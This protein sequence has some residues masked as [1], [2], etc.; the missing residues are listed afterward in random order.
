[1]DVIATIQEKVRRAI[2]EGVPEH[3]GRQS[4]PLVRRD[5]G[6]A[7]PPNNAV[8]RAR[9]DFDTRDKELSHHPESPR[10][11]ELNEDGSFASSAQMF[12]SMVTLQVLDGRRLVLATYCL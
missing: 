8:A 4:G 12:R 10:K 5:I 2:F 11:P 9:S 1:M 3:G 7:A 6:D